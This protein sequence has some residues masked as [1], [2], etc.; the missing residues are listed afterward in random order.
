MN[1]DVFVAG[2]RIKRSGP[3]PVSQFMELCLNDPAHGYYMTRDPFGR[4]GDFTTSPEVSQMFGELI[5]VWC[6]SVWRMMG[7]PENVRLVELGP[8]RGTMMLDILRA[9]RVVPEFRNAVVV[10]MVEVSPALQAR[11][12]QTL[13][14]IDVPV[15]W[16]NA[17]EDVPEGPLIIV[18]NEF[19]DAL[20]VHQ[21]VKQINGWYERTVEVDLYGNLAFG[22]G[23]EQLS[24]FE[25]ML[26]KKVRDA[27][28]G[29]I[30]EWRID[31]VAL[32]MARGVAKLPAFSVKMF[33]R[34]LR[35]MS[36]PLVELSMEEEAIAMCEIYTSDDYREFKA[37]KAE[38][39][40]P[41]YRNR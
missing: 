33:R 41:L 14:G 9:A 6:A 24:L 1:E 40:D 28:I 4:G 10:H 19:F 38:N 20:P 16:H 2:K 8:G 15:L 32:E 13:G 27:P 7:S 5:G 25:Q 3:M 36:I 23:S 11:Q 18:A 12:K 34:S 21:A 26:P 35:R 30:Y 29:S 37:A 39:R 31:R 17:F 22:T